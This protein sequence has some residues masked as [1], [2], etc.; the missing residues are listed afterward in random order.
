[1]PAV[2]KDDPMGLWER[3]RARGGMLEPEALRVLEA[4]GVPVVRHGFARSLEEAEEAARRLGFPVV[5]KVVSPAIMHKSDVGGVETAVADPAGLAAAWARL[6]RLEGFAGV[7]IA[8]RLSGL[9]L[10]FGAKID[11]QFGPVILLGLGGTAVEIYRDVVTRLAPL[12]ERDVASM[13]CCLRGARLLTGFRGCPAVSLPKLTAALLA[14]SRLVVEIAE[15][16]DSID[17]N[18]VFCTP[19][20][21][22]VADARILLAPTP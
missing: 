9:E 16:I 7:L 13:V 2:L 21:C 17:L 6:S 22:V 1:M 12:R 8:E 11:E 14:F 19:E 4:A 20:R 3:A 15:R 10:I 18:P 5:A